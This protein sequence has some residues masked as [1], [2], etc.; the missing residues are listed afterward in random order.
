MK[1]TLESFLLIFSFLTSAWQVETRGGPYPDAVIEFTLKDN[2][3]ATSSHTGLVT[4]T[5]LG[6]TT[7]TA[8]A[9]THPKDSTRK[10]VY[11][12]VR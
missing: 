9:L 12:K 10:I 2:E 3:I 11:S 5:A 6:T 1:L 8:A 7:L 4:A